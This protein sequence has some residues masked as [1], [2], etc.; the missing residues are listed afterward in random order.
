MRNRSRT[1]RAIA[2]AALGALV[3]V[4][5]TYAAQK[6]IVP[7]A[8]EAPSKAPA[9][10]PPVPATSSPRAIQEDVGQRSS[11]KETASPRPQSPA[12]KSSSLEAPSDVVK[13]RVRSAIE[14]ELRVLRPQLERSTADAGIGT[15]EYL[16]FL[17]DRLRLEERERALESLAEGR[18]RIVQGDDLHQPVFG[19]GWPQ[20]VWNVAGEDGPAWVALPIPKDLTTMHNRIEETKSN[21]A[22]EI[23]HQHNRLRSEERNALKVA[24]MTGKPWLVEGLLVMQLQS[25]FEYAPDSNLLR[26]R[27]PR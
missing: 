2:I 18:A 11:A 12:A 4:L 15:K 13:A 17:Q 9:D 26:R 16:Q 10:A 6:E 27:T 23:I 5:A 14:M 8:F 1:T 3:I 7:A 22:D 24:Y 20:L 19:E 21:L 25:R